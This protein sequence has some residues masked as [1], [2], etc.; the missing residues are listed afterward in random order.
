MYIAYYI[1]LLN[2]KKKQTCIYMDVCKKIHLN[3]KS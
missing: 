3:E 2:N 1:T